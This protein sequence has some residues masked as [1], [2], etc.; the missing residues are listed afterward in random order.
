MINFNPFFSVAI[1]HRTTKEVLQL[2][3]SLTNDFPGVTSANE[4][5]PIA[6]SLKVTFTLGYANSVEIELSPD[7]K[8]WKILLDS[9]PSWFELG[10][11]IMIEY[12]YLTPVRESIKFVTMIND[13]PSVSFGTSPSFTITGAGLGFLPL[14]D[15]KY[16]DT[17]NEYNSKTLIEIL[18]YFCKKYGM[19]LSI[20]SEISDKIKNSPVERWGGGTNEWHNLYM[21]LAEHRCTM[22]NRGDEL[23]VYNVDEMMK[24]EPNFKLVWGKNVNIVN[25]NEGVKV[26]PIL[27]FESGFEKIFMSNE[28]FGLKTKILSPDSNNLEISD[29]IPALGQGFPKLEL[30]KPSD[31]KVNPAFFNNSYGNL[32]SAR[33]NMIFDGTVSTIGDVE[34]IGGDV[35]Y[36]ENISRFLDGNW[37]VFSKTDSIDS[38]GFT[39][40]MD[41]KKNALPKDFITE[42]AKEKNEQSPPQKLPPN[43]KNVSPEV[44]GD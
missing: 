44:E 20:R 1:K 7:M 33:Q 35:V 41:I 42:L 27:E 11:W 28:S 3:T 23:I 21:V 19:R 15:Y 40:S 4:I 16:V 24:R 8:I 36:I 32:L 9:N 38:N 34:I 29:T 25:R 31:L 10:N 2:T 43:T 12:G 14:S 13:L 39:T 6:S 22:I 18:N 17:N 37:L 26:L 5:Y 30:D